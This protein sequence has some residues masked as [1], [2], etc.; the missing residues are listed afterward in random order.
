[1]T[2][3]KVTKGLDIP[4]EGAPWGPVEQLDTPQ[5]IAYNFSFSAFENIKFRLLVSTGDR[6]KIGQPLAEDKDIPGR[7]FV[8][9]ASGI[10]HEIVRGDKRH[11]VAIVIQVFPHEEYL[12]R[13]PIDVDAI[14][15]EELM[16]ELLAGGLYVHIRTR[17]FYRLPDPKKLP[18]SVFIKAIESAPLVPPAEMQVEG[19]EE[20]FEA[21]IRALSKLTGAPIHLVYRKDSP[22]KA[23]RDARYVEKHTVEGPHPAGNVSVHIQHIDPIRKPQDIIWTLNVLGVLHIGSF[24]LHGRLA[25]DR[26]VSVGG[27]AILPLKRR[28][29]RARFGHPIAELVAGRL[30]GGKSI[31]IISGDVL[32][33]DKVQEK[34]FLGFSHTACMALFEP[35]E[36]PFVPFMRLGSDTY[37]AS[38]TYISGFFNWAARRFAFTTSQHGQR[39]AFMDSAIYDRM[40][41]L[42]ILSL[43]LIRACMAENFDLAEKY[44]LLEVAPED[45]ALLEFVDPSKIEIMDIVKGALRRHYKDIIG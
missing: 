21:G 11:L 41:P 39:R 43:P 6:V 7:M 16:S 34:D 24:L 37:T 13:P 27:P 3:I 10:I 20:E 17:P 42:N 36:R 32:T 14:S 35:E 9:C 31:R 22:C 19:R 30:T 25:L 45:F 18:R 12:S 28:Y 23:F 44:G 40:M 2:H 5:F 15:K 1:M 29:V 8:S 33:G 38:R 26:I 4:I